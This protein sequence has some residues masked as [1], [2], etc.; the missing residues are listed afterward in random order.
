MLQRQMLQNLEQVAPLIFVPTNERECD[1]LVALLD[2]ITDAVR[3]DETHPLANLMDV[4]GTLIE[5]Y[6]DQ[7]IPEPESD[8]ISVL[9]HFMD[10]YSLKPKDLAELGTADT[11]S[12][13]LD[14]SRE[15]DLAQIKALC[16]RFKVPASVF[17]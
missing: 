5:T 4:L 9:K 16:K 6:E 15:L 14:G 3:D 11:V 1:Q 8:P 13:I 10:E 17:V 2:E 12:E 7:F